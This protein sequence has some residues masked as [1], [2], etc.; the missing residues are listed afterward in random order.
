[1]K[2]QRIKVVAAISPNDA[3]PSQNRVLSSGTAIR[4]EVARPST[5]ASATIP[6]AAQW[7]GTFPRWNAPVLTRIKR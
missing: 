1:M 3:S 5:E 7:V 4:S 2:S 6:N